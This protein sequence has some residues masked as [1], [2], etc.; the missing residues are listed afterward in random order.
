MKTGVE[1]KMS[2]KWKGKGKTRPWFILRILQVRYIYYSSQELIKNH[3]RG[4]AVFK[5]QF[6]FLTKCR[7]A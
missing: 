1:E 3:K 6:F 7:V 5:S 4:L 2:A